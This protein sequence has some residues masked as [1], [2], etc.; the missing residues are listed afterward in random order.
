V[1]VEHRNIREKLE[2]L[3]AYRDRIPVLEH[4]G[5]VIIEGNPSEDEV[6]RALGGL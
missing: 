5:R 2:W 3:R 6:E 1:R 4:D